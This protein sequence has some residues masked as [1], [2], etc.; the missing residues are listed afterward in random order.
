GWTE[1]VVVEQTRPLPVPVT[2]GPV[3]VDGAPRAD[4]PDY[5]ELDVMANG[6][7]LPPVSVFTAGQLRQ[8]VHLEAPVLPVRVDSVHARL[9]YRYDPSAPLCL[10]IVGSSCTASLPVDPRDTEGAL[11]ESPSA[12]LVLQVGWS[13]SDPASDVT[14]TLPFAGQVAGSVLR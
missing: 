14:L 11:H 3:R 12:Q 1:R 9:A 10:V 2:I 13:G 6:V 4:N 5:Y 7:M 8:P